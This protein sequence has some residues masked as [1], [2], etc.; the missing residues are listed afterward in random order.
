MSRWIEK[1]NCCDWLWDGVTFREW[2]KPFVAR[3]WP[4]IAEIWIMGLRH[5]L[6]RMQSEVSVE[7]IQNNPENAYSGPGL[8]WKSHQQYPV[9]SADDRYQ[10]RR[11][12]NLN[13]KTGGMRL[14]TGPVSWLSKWQKSDFDT[15]LLSKG[16]VTLIPER[17]CTCH[18]S[19][20]SSSRGASL[21]EK[22]K[23]RKENEI[24][25][26]MSNW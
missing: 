21:R 3:R 8:I 10:K 14:S 19:P 25:S 9:F 18:C 2:E 17:F 24:K 11:T 26:E 5:I 20:V 1:D 16:E 13:P 15:G 6:W 23:R 7:D 4:Y 12:W 22:E